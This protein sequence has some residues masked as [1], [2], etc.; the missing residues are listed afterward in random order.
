M[1]IDKRFRDLMVA[2][3]DLFSD[4]Q[5]VTGDFLAEHN[6]T[7]DE[8]IDLFDTI[9]IAVKGYA[10]IDDETRDR[11]LLAG[12]SSEMD[13]Q[14]RDILDKVY[15]GDQAMKKIASLRTPTQEHVKP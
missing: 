3:G 15:K 14:F 11:L 6:V 7:S 9:G 8:C 2:A 10:L 4:G 5:Y 12:V 1:K 13:D